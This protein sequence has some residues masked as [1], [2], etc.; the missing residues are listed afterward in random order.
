MGLVISISPETIFSLGT[1]GVTN[2]YFTSIILLLSMFIFCVVFIPKNLNKIP[3]A[4]SLQ[5][6]L[7]LLMET[8]LHFYESIVGKTRARQ[9]FAFL[10][11]LFIFILLSSWSGLLPGVGSIGIH[12]IHEG[13]KELI[14]LFRSPSADLNTTIALAILGMLFVQYQGFSSLGIKYLKKFFQFHSPM[15]TFVGFLELLGEFTKII[16]FAFRLFGNIFAGEVLLAVMSFLIPIFASL[17]FL[18]L[19]VFVGIIQSLVFTML[20]IV[21]ALGATKAQH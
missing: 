16:S 10:T 18:G 5:N 13:E 12:A 6:I 2:S 7:E 3:K 8:F 9:W 19:E 11:T 20:V 4:Y 14:P 21:F 1:F 15:M 17:P